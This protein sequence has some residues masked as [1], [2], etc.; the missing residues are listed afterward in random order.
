M[1]PTI[2]NQLGLTQADFAPIEQAVMQEN[3]L[4]KGKAL[5]TPTMLQIGVAGTA[6][7]LDSHVWKSSLI[8]ALLI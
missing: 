5:V 8:S 3:D 4:E 2:L 7:E 1:S 6:Q